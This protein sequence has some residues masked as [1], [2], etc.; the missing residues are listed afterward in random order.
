MIA[1]GDPPL[2]S[3]QEYFQGKSDE[4]GSAL[5]K[6]AVGS[7]PAYSYSMS[8]AFSNSNILAKSQT[9]LALINIA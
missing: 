8:G 9:P 5:T 7:I 1:P 4:L 3:L 2:Q 6:M